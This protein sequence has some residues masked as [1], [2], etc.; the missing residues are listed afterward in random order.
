MRNLFSAETFSLAAAIHEA[1]PFAMVMM[2]A[3][4]HP[5]VELPEPSSQKSSWWPF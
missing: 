2:T 4:S 5:P 3:P 1:R